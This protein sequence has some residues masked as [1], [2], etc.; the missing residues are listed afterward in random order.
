M[1]LVKNIFQNERLGIGNTMFIC[2]REGH[3]KVI[4][5]MT[6]VNRC[7]FTF[8]IQFILRIQMFYQFYKSKYN[9]PLHAIKSDTSNF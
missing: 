9:G 5:N 7:I 2:A 8:Q 1:W 4:I 3:T 6:F